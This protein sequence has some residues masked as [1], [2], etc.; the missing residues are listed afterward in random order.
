MA[1]DGELVAVAGKRL[2]KR[3]ATE[4]AVWR[5]LAYAD[6]IDSAASQILQALCNIGGWDLGELWMLD[7][8][9]GILRLTDFWH[10]SPLDM[11][12]FIAISRE[13]TFV[14]GIG[15]PGMVW[16]SGTPK[17]IEDVVAHPNF[18][19]ARFAGEVGIH[20][21]FG[22]PIRGRNQLIGVMTFYSPEFRKPDVDLLDSLDVIG[23]QIGHFIGKVR[24]QQ[25]LAASEARWQRIFT[26]APIGI[27]HS[28]PGGRL[29]DVNPAFA[30]ILGYASPSETLRVVN[31]TSIPEALY[32]DAD[33]RTELLRRVQ[34]HRGRWASI[35]VLGRRP[36][37]GVV[38]TLLQVR[39]LD[40]YH[41]EQNVLEGFLIDISER[42]Q[43]EQALQAA[44]DE[45]RELT[46]RDHLT[47]LHNRRHL[48]ERMDIEIAAAQRYREDVAVIMID[49]DHFK[50][51][52]D[53][54]GH[55]AGDALLQNLAST[56]RK[57]V[58]PD[59][60]L[61]RY[62]GEEFVLLMRRTNAQGAVEAAERLRASV[63]QVPVQTDGQ[64]LKLTVS[65]GVAALSECS[66][67]CQD[68]LLRMADQRMYKA[69]AQ[70]RNLVVGPD[71][72]QL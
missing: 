63:E 69:K 22:F 43:M 38:T 46:L 37:G 64:T 28:L 1:G 34:E 5:I 9:E 70:G 29:L 48:E 7:E 51:V 39:L 27:F 2:E 33:A 62:G 8:R 18:P 44:L 52:N 56:L 26:G 71:R 50:V 30:S 35:E 13:T 14:K 41:G 31:R 53:T 19:R 49:I 3:R 67:R 20:A 36:D 16:S 55:S 4:H 68:N 61:A 12:E 15:L 32:V 58:R 60:I 54:Y 6:D 23:G 47:G 45:V 72:S 40:E 21:A 24:A 17:W 59:D 25:A 42:K 65:C 11:T 66:D 57:E 10:N